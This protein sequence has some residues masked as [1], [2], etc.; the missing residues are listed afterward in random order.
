MTGRPSR[1]ICGVDTTSC[2][3]SPTRRVPRGGALRPEL[4]GARDA[5]SGLNLAVSGG[6]WGTRCSAS[7][8][9]SCRIVCSSTRACVWQHTARLDDTTQFEQCHDHVRCPRFVQMQLRCELWPPAP[10]ALPDIAP[11]PAAPAHATRGVFWRKVQGGAPLDAARDFFLRGNAACP[12]VGRTAASW[13]S[14]DAAS[15][16]CESVGINCWDVD[17]ETDASDRGKGRAFAF[18]MI[19]YQVIQSIRGTATADVSQW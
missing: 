19:L 17:L 9:R 11:A 16:S 3:G 12:A 15:G 7:W 14:V 8:L 6:A 2:S 10:R 18:D 1:V 13:S 4:A 5:T